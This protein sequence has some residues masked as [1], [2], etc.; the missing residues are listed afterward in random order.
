MPPLTYL[1]VCPEDSEN[2]TA[3]WASVL[4]LGVFDQIISVKVQDYVN[5]LITVAVCSFMQTH[6]H[7]TAS[8]FSN[9]FLVASYLLD[10][11]HSV[12]NSPAWQT[13]DVCCRLLTGSLASDDFLVRL[14]NLALAESRA[15]GRG[16]P[17]GW[18]STSFIFNA[19]TIASLLV[20]IYPF[21]F[22]ERSR[23]F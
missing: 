21:I 1:V 23:N 15:Q 6:G 8:H 14:C 19:L 3:F 7:H 18:L 17:R 20:P 10:H 22:F 2:M 9:C 11:Y 16:P 5:T 4:S 12:N 13:N